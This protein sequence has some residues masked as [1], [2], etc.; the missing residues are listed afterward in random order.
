MV[1]VSGSAVREPANLLVPLGSSFAAA[2]EACGGFLSPPGK[3]IMGGPMMG[4]AQYTLEVPVIKGTSGILALSPEE[5][6]YQAPG[7]PVCIRCGRCVKA[8]PMGLVPTYLANYSYF[9]RLPELERLKVN[10][11]IECG[12]CAYICPTRNPLVHHQAGKAEAAR[13]KDAAGPAEGGRAAGPGA[14]DGGETDGA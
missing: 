1:T 12:C 9:G 7:E 10:D 5:V 4:L 13:Y 3:V 14:G 11:C 6:A 8:C 2:V